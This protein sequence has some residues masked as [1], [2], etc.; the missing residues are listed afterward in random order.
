MH[1]CRTDFLRL[2]SGF[3]DQ[4]TLCK[5]KKYFFHSSSILDMNYNLII[6]I[7]KSQVLFDRIRKIPLEK[8]ESIERKFLI[9]IVTLAKKMSNQTSAELNLNKPWITIS[10]RKKISRIDLNSI[11]GHK[12]Y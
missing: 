5:R 11:K 1:I 2:G 4:I 9:F 12:R 7:T 8:L 10:L 6:K 3:T